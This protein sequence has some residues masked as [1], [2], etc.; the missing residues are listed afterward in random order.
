VKPQQVAGLHQI[1]RVKSKGRERLVLDLEISVGAKEPHDSV[2]I[3]GNP[4]FCMRIE[5]GIGGGT[6]TIGALINTIPKIINAPPGLRT[7]MELPVP[8]AF[9]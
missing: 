5:G 9:G 7:M 2:E 6:A 3:I 1:M 4:P 8:Y